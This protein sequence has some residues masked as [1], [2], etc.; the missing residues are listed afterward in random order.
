MHLYNFTDDLKSF[1]AKRLKQLTDAYEKYIH[2]ENG[3]I[4]GVLIFWRD[5]GVC[6]I[7]EAFFKSA[8][9]STFLK[10]AMRAYRGCSEIVYRTTISNKPMVKL[11]MGYCTSYDVKDQFVFFIRKRA[12]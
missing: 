4:R 1:V 6:V 12:I 8:S 11:G 5:N 3:R 10:Y 7:I 9:K 2:Y